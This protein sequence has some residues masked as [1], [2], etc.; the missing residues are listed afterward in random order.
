MRVTMR[1]RMLTILLAVVLI[2]LLVPG[3]AR[4]DGPDRRAA[5]TAYTVEAGDT[6]WG[7]ARRVAPDR[8]PREVVDQMVRDN[9]LHGSLQVGQRLLV[10]VP[11]G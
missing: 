1:A 9:R 5:R 11:T 6:L 3:L 10:P 4:G 7:I 2:L 8:D